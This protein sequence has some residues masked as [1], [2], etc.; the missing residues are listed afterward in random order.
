MHNDEVELA[1][2]PELPG[3]EGAF[4]YTCTCGTRIP[5]SVKAQLQG[6]HVFP[7]TVCAWRVRVEYGGMCANV[8]HSTAARHALPDGCLH[9]R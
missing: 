9:A 4:C 5:I 8:W 2:L 1:T 3:Q 7:C 6:Q